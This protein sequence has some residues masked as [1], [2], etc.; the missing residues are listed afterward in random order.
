MAGDFTYISVGDF[1]DLFYKIKQKGYTEIVSK[2]H[3]SNQAR[4]VSKWNAETASSDFWIIP[5]IRQRWN[6]KCTGDPF[7]EYEDYVVAKYFSGT[8]GL[9]MLSVGCGTGFRERKFGKYPNFD[10][11]EGIDIAARQVG[12]ARKMAFDLN[13]HNIKYYAA[14][15]MTHAFEPGSYDCVLF[16][17][18]LHHFRDIPDILLNKVLPILKEGGFLII[19][20]YSNYSFSHEYRKNR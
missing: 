3:L 5:E 19:F 9:K 15:F 4:T 16:N 13:L 6:E 10:L 18:S 7:L 12:E 2:F 8:R 11:I 17:S 14:D 20:E 1:I